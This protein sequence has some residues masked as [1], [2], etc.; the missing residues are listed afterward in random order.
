MDPS[1][2]AFYLSRAHV[3][4]TTL[5]LLVPP[6]VGGALVAALLAAGA[7][8]LPRAT[9]AA[10][11]ILVAAGLAVVGVSLRRQGQRRTPWL[12]VSAAGVQLPQGFLVPWSH[13]AAI[14]APGPRTLAGG[15]VHLE[16]VPEHARLRAAAQGLTSWAAWRAAF[17]SPVFTSR[18]TGAPTV[19]LSPASVGVEPAALVAVLERHRDAA[20]GRRS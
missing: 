9:G 15:L 12:T 5:L 14:R 8:P 11:A 10:F 6:G 4:R 13:V 16:L 2:T 18:W 20:A 17:T 1:P 7:L 19:Y 3:R